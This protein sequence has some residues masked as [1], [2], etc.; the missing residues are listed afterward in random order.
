MEYRI[1]MDIEGAKTQQHIYPEFEIDG[2]KFTHTSLPNKKHYNTNFSK[3]LKFNADIDDITKKLDGIFQPIE[4]EGVFKITPDWTSWLLRRLKL[5]QMGNI[6][7]P[8]YEHLYELEMKRIA[9]R[10]LKKIMTLQTVL[11]T[12]QNVHWILKI[13]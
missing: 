3:N 12:L 1:L 13:R 11:I 5:L 2:I 8:K 6:G 7:H 10:D 9:K 4:K